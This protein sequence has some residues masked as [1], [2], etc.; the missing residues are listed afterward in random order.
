MHCKN[1]FVHTATSVRESLPDHPG[2]SLCLLDSA[3]YYERIHP[4]VLNA[5]ALPLIL[6]FNTPVGHLSSQ[7]QSSFILPS[8]SLWKGPHQLTILNSVIT[9][10]PSIELNRG[11]NIAREIAFIT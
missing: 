1:R 4:V 5:I 10:F 7:P 11:L 8:L 3:D 2:R 6:P 9:T